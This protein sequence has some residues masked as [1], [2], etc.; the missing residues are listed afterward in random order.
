M[1]TNKFA[2]RSAFGSIVFLC[3]ACALTPALADNWP[4]W[5]NGANNAGSSN[6]NILLPLSEQWHS[7]APL[8]EENGVVVAGGIA[9]MAT[10]DGW[11]FAF[12]VTTGFDV[13]GYPV[14]IVHTWGSPAV[15]VA[16]GLIYGLAGVNLYAFFLNGTPAW[17]A[18]VGSVGSNYS[19]GPVVDEGFVY[20]KA[21]GN[22]RKYSAAGALQWSS[23]AGGPNTQPAI[24]GAHVYS[25]SET[26]QIQ[27]FDK[28]TGVQITTGGFPI[29]TG[30]GVTAL[31]AA[32]GRL[33]LKSDVLYAYDADNGSLLWSQPDGGYSTYYGTPAVSG[34]VVYTYGWDARIYAFDVSTGA[35]MA[36]FPSIALSNLNDRNWSSP[37]V[38]G[39]KVFIG[40]GTSQMLKVLGAAGS[41][42]AGQVLAEYLTFSTD[43]QGFDLCSAA[44]SDGWVFAMLD[45]GGLYA[46]FGG[47][48]N[49][50]SGALVINGGAE[51]TQSQAATLSLD[52]N[53]NADVVEM[54]ISEDP[55]FS[56][57]PWI[58]Y[59]ASSSWTLSPGYGMKTVYSQLRDNG[60]L[61]SNVFT[62]QIDYQASCE[63]SVCVWVDSGQ[64]TEHATSYGTAWGDYDNDG[65]PDL[66]V[67]NDG[68]NHLYENVNGVLTLVPN[69]CNDDEPSYSAAWGDYDNDGDLDL[70]VVND[71]VGN[72]LY[73]ND[74]GAFTRVDAGAAADGGSGY[75]AA[76]ADYD[77]DGDLDLYV[78]NRHG[79]NHLYRNDDAV[80]VSAGGVTEV[81]GTSRGCAFADYDNDGDQDLYV[82]RVGVNYLF[83]N[84]NGVFVDVSAAPVNDAGDG[85]GVA[86]G[87]YDNDGD[88]DLYLVNTGG[89][90][91]LFRNDFPGGFFTDVTDPLTGDPENGRAC[92]WTDYNN[93]GWLDLFLANHTGGNH[94]FH[95]TGGAFADSTCGA[96]AATANLSTWG[97]A[98]ADYD[99]DGDQDLAVAVRT[100]SETSKL[101]RNDL[102]SSLARS[103]LQVD[104]RGVTSNHFGVG[105]RI[106]VDTG[107]LTLMREVSASGSYLSQAP[108]TASF[109]L[110]G[111]TTVNMT[112]RWP[113]GVVQELTD[114]PVNRRIEIVEQAGSTGTPALPHSP[115]LV[116][117][118][119]PNPFNPSTTFE[120]SIPRNSNVDLQIVDAGGRIVR[121]LLTGEPLSAGFHQV[122]WQGLD[123][124]GMLAPSG[125]YFYRCLAAGETVTGRMLLLK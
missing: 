54:R 70:Y 57:A 9:Y 101:F 59:M 122:Q 85:K 28:A 110:A 40:A 102:E 63:G 33:F 124:A 29:N 61:L 2:K 90:N 56:G 68:P 100:Y 65:D 78:C 89:A 64:I 103:W 66:L 80:F 118:N 32:D 88:L 75:N 13:P 119:F 20:L 105:A 76:W 73:R 111:A 19:E 11:L 10:D 7:T 91:K 21:G 60:G 74:A 52:N 44:V 50:P 51:C 45:G 84:D 3:L 72:A 97:C 96:L 22:L 104:L 120:L 123:D 6:E 15:D 112:V 99:L 116:V 108:L 8:V 55:F 83:R 16:N 1:T 69:W 109:G 98:F 24:M 93:D 53:G 125:V 48:G 113:S 43:A 114:V 12:D 41:A 49:P 121:R 38:A 36:G 115:L 14:Q 67:A 106:T 107:D 94:L 26:G 42:E 92:A 4:M 79:T 82:S 23:A 58:P 34:A 81:S 117:S 47:A 25:N 87:D 39:N 46:F 62:D 27:K 31:T 35:T 30:Y 5:R 71:S 37:A 86:W 17:T 18:S 95:N 77:N